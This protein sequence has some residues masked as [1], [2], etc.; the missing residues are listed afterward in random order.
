VLEASADLYILWFL[1]VF[2]SKE[3]NMATENTQSSAKSVNPDE[4]AH[5][6]SMAETSVQ[7]IT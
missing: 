7:T 6:S 1:F 5:F 3:A 2:L 4:I